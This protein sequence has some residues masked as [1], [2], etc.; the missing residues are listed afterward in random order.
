LLL[1]IDDDI[2]GVAAV[3]IWGC[4][5]AQFVGRVEKFAGRAAEAPH[6]CR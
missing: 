1:D 5:P 4:P 6:R 2:D 3:G